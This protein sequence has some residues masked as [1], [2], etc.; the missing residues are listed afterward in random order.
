MLDYRLDEELTALRDSVREFAVERVAP[1]I[2]EFYEADKF[3]Y[4]LVAQMGKMGLFGLPFPEEYGGM[5]GD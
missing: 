5:G 2:G 1:V 3:P 4:E